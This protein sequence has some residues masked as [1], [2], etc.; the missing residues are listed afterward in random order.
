MVC[1]YNI[2]VVVLIRS[3]AVWPQDQQQQPHQLLQLL[4]LASQLASEIEV[5]HEPFAKHQINIKTCGSF[6]SGSGQI[7]KARLLRG[8][9]KTICFSLRD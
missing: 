3:W 6:T 4:C 2:K 9:G 8:R 5:T 1:R 7:K